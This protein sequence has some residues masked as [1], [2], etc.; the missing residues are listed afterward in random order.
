[1][2]TYT[3]E[4]DRLAT[5]I[6]VL[7]SAFGIKPLTPVQIADAITDIYV[8]DALLYAVSEHYYNNLDNETFPC[9]TVDSAREA[10]LLLTAELLSMVDS[11]VSKVGVYSIISALSLMSDNPASAY[12]FANMVNNALN[13]PDSEPLDIDRRLGSLGTLISMAFSRGLPHNE[14]CKIFRESIAETPFEV[15]M[16][17]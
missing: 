17:K 14:V 3:L 15:V 10:Q 1:M 7:S 12:E 11:A 4:T 5:V 8:R 16:S 6:T 9:V 13:H 2:T